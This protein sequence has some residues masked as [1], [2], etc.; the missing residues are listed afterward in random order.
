MSYAAFIEAY[1]AFADAPQA[2]VEA[3]LT[4]AI[5]ETSETI[6]GDQ[7]QTGVFLKTADILAMTPEGKAMRLSSDDGKSIYH[8]RLLRLRR[9]VATGAHRVA[10]H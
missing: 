2:L 1:P 6:W 10:G 3:A 7:Y 5:A 4:E 9:L 8:A